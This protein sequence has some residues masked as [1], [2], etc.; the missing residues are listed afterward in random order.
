[1]EMIQKIA[2]LEG[3]KKD[4]KNTFDSHKGYWGPFL[5]EEESLELCD[6][7][8][9]DDP[10]AKNEKKQKFKN[11]YTVQQSSSSSLTWA[12]DTYE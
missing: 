7:K 11:K 3:W 9:E 10:R 5:T 1:M 8:F 6:E 4:D 12:E 2:R